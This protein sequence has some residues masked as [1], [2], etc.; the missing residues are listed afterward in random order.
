MFD[1]GEAV[2]CSMSRSQLVRALVYV[3]SQEKL[4]HFL[5][6]FSGIG[7]D[8]MLDLVTKPSE[9]NELTSNFL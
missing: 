7:I 1:D 9:Q 6:F 4:F 5:V 8:A 3:W 2:N